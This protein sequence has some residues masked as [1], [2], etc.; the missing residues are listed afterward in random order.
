LEHGKIAALYCQDLIKNS[1][2]LCKIYSYEVSK[3][4]QKLK[5]ERGSSA[6]NRNSGSGMKTKSVKIKKT[7]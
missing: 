7:P 3:K 1:A 5:P 6:T 4:K 2:S